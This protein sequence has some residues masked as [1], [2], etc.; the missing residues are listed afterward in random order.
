LRD[1]LNLRCLSNNNEF[2]YVIG[3]PCEKECGYHSKNNTEIHY[4]EATDYTTSGIA[5]NWIDYIVNR[6]RENVFFYILGLNLTNLDYSYFGKGNVHDRVFRIYNRFFRTALQ[7]SVKYYFSEFDRIV[8]DKIIHDKSDALE[9]HEY[10]PWHSIYKLD[11]D[12]VLDFRSEKIEFL[13]S[14][15]RESQ[16]EYSHFLQ[17]IDLIL[18]VSYNSLHYSSKNK[19]KVE[20]ADEFLPL[21]CRLINRPANINSEYSYVRRMSVDFFPKHDISDICPES[22]KFEFEMKRMDSFYK[23][24]ELKL[25]NRNRMSL[26]DN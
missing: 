22:N 14:D 7:K 19:K 13:D 23:K 10:F 12:D 15:H 25:K 17:L 20:I 26:F 8:I 5:K 9:T 11:E 2:N 3:N 24:R 1:L 4:K 16:N 18:G 6:D 21:L